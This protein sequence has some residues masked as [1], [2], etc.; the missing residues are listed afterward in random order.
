MFDTGT[1]GWE[2]GLEPVP[3][4]SPDAPRAPDARVVA[5]TRNLLAPRAGAGASMS[6]SRVGLVLGAGGVLGGA[7]LVG[8]LHAIEAE[9]G[10]E[11]GSADYI[12]GTSAGSMVGALLA[13]GVE[14]ELMVARSHGRHPRRP[15][16]RR[17]VPAASAPAS[18]SAPARGAWPPRRLRARP[19]T[20]RP[21][22]SRA[23]CRAG[24]SR[25]S[26]S[27]S[28]FAAPSATA[29]RGRRTPTTGRWPWTMPA[30]GGSPSVN[31]TR[32][33][34]V[35]QTPWPRR[36]RSPGSTG[37]WRSMGAGTSTV[38]STRSRTSTSS[39]PS[40]STW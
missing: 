32:R 15:R 13:C 22:S 10:W 4:A 27:S 12:V 37:R 33:P 21:P 20:P 38:V 14:T 11:P 25:P 19:V 34:P 5:L 23:G 31:R 3:N 24:S 36:V 2:L 6:G 39:A 1:L 40:R 28:R 9:T 7:W 16:R 29:A 30:V 17:R 26:R 18:G 35:Y 8:A